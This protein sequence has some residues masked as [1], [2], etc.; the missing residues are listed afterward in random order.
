MTT[1]I[2]YND[3]RPDMP[4]KSESTYTWFLTIDD[5]VPNVDYEAT[6]TVIRR[7][8]ADPRG[9]RR[10]GYRFR[11]MAPARG[12]HLKYVKP[13]PG[14]LIHIRIATDRTISR[15]CH[16]TGLSCAMMGDDV[17]LI[18][19]D[20]WLRA[21]AASGLSLDE[22]RTYVILHEVGHLLGRAHHACAADDARKPCPVMYQQ[23]ISKGCCAPNPWPLAWE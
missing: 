14:R 16:F 23:T 20:R 13:R 10:F 7:V 18:N 8:L 2:M 22:Y 15:T 12:L 11:A 3:C 19:Q 5:D 6:R 9:W 17:V 4:S 1:T 21:S